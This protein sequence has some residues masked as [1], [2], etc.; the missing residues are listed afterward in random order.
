MFIDRYLE[1]KN[2]LDPKWIRQDEMEFAW[3]CEFLNRQYSAGGMTYLEI[4]SRFGGSMFVA[5]EFLAKPAHIVCVDQPAMGWGSKKSDG[6][7]KKLAKTVRSEGHTVEI[8]FADSQIEKTRDDVERRLAGREVDVL[9]LDA[10]HTYKGVSRDFEL[11]SSLVRPGGII[12]FHDV[13][14]KQ[15]NPKVEVPLF[16]QSLVKKYPDSCRQC[17]HQAGRFGI[18]VLFKP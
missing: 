3:F 5:A 13:A 7:L 4:G 1:R 6:P 2:R 8:V 16:W 11:Y 12:A 14:P 15:E 18:G 10:D 17:V 9:F